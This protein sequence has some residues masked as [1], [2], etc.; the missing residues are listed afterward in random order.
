LREEDYMLIDSIG[1]SV[2][3]EWIR[4]EKTILPTF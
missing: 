3:N 4:R 2:A 1:R